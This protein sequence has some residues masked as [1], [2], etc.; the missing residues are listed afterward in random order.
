M[1]A[2]FI[3]L[4]WKPF[5]AL[6]DDN[7]WPSFVA[8]KSRKTRLQSSQWAALLFYILR[9]L[10]KSDLIWIWIR[11]RNRFNSKSEITLRTFWW[12]YLVPT[13]AYICYLNKSKLVI[14]RYRYINRN[15]N[16]NAFMIALSRPL[17][18]Y[19]L[20]LYS[21]QIW[22]LPIPKLSFNIKRSIQ[23]LIY[24]TSLL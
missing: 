10:I 23:S 4:I 19:H 18:R 22:D 17:T 11:D 5:S 21:F 14:G 9:F 6:L 1:N 16:R 2:C 12:R 7:L 20:L 15:R 24:L 3:D 13:H 8:S